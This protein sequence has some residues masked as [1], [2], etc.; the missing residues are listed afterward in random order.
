VPATEPSARRKGPV[1]KG[2]PGGGNWNSSSA[3]RSA[4]HRCTTSLASAAHDLKDAALDHLRLCRRFA[5]G[6]TG[7]TDERQ[8]EVLARHGVELQTTAKFIQDFLTYSV[9]ETGEMQL[10]FEMGD[11]KREPGGSVQLVVTA[12]S[13][14]GIGAVLSRE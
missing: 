6:E 14:K 10:R 2:L 9:L 1:S 12:L 3:C 11:L 5:G 4:F 8:R 7:D 13:G